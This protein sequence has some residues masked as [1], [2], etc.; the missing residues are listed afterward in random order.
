MFFDWWTPIDNLPIL[1]KGALLSISLTILVFLISI[2]F[3][4]LLGLLRFNRDNKITYGLATIY[5]EFIR[6]TPLLVQIFFIYFGLPQFN[7][8]LPAMLSGIIG[9]S[10]NNSAYI[11]EIIRSGIQSI[12]KGQWEA[13]KCLGLTKTQIF[14]NVIYP[15]ALRNIFPSLINQFVMILFGTSLLSVL[16]IRD[17]T[18]VSSI[19]NSQTFRTFEIFSVAIIIYYCMTFV[20]LRILR[21]INKKYFPSISSTEVN[22]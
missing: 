4:T 7:I 9:L 15:Q 6:N 14:I 16:D 8:Y 5:I 20:I 10:I 18:Q 22:R 2:I 12:S 17:L 21:T 11:A 1:L 13:S 3:G 19:L